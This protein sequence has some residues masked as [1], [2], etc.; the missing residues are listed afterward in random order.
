MS[1]FVEIT[2]EKKGFHIDLKELWN[3]R[4]LVF[5]LVRKNFALSYKQT[6]LGPLWMLFVP[7][8]YAAVHSI[9]FGWIAEMSTGG[10]PVF[11]FYLCS[12]SIW[13]MFSACIQ[14][15]IN[16]FRENQ[17]LFG[18]V[19]FPRLTV[20]VSNIFIN[21]IIFLVQIIPSVV[22]IAVF[23]VRGVLHPL[24]WGWLLLPLVLFHLALLGMGCGLIVSSVTVKYRDLSVL[25]SA[26]VSIWMYASPVIYP[27]SQ[28]KE[29]W[30]RR[31]VL[32]NPVT[33][34]LELCRR[35]LLGTGEIAAVAVGSSVLITLIILFVGIGVFNR[36]EQDFIDT[37]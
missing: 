36:T 31:L 1:Y 33:A 13:G 3:Y 7:V 6:I 30:L 2:S 28:V 23:T 20:P 16:V 29:G 37:V 26:G 32:L 35:I 19:F 17:G 4:Y 18:K 12:N 9:V 10:T 8:L 24:W 34:P 14:R 15:N 21:L 5:L 11:L 27:L 25:A 22:L